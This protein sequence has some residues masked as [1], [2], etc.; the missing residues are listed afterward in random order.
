[1]EDANEKE[2]RSIRLQGLCECQREGGEKERE[3]GRRGNRVK[4]RGGGSETD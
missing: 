3:H 1:M 2:P 4:R